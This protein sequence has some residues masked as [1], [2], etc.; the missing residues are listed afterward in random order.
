MDASIEEML[1]SPT[2]GRIVFVQ[3][4]VGYAASYGATK[5]ATA[6]LASIATEYRRQ[7][8]ASNISVSVVNADPSD[9]QPTSLLYPTVCKLFG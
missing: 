6:A 3:Q 4:E 9:I 5:V 1:S 2:R 8:S 7:H